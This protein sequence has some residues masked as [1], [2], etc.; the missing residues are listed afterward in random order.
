MH[1]SGLLS[2]GLH[3][4]RIKL[5][6]RGHSPH[7]N[8]LPGHTAAEHRTKPPHASRER[9]QCSDET[10]TDSNVYLVIELQ[11]VKVSQDGN[12]LHCTALLRLTLNVLATPKPKIGKALK[13][14]EFSLSK[15]LLFTNG[16]IGAYLLGQAN[17]CS[18]HTFWMRNRDC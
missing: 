7:P 2:C 15:K 17:L 8:K 5:Q 10:D 11:Y 12:I 13:I 6:V 4:N 3:I 16:H 18:R 14:V 1:T 9:M